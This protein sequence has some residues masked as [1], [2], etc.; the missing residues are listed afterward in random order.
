MNAKL[1][2]IICVLEMNPI[3][4]IVCSLLET[5]FTTWKDGD[6]RDIL[7]IGQPTTSL[8]LNIK[9]KWPML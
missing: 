3:N 5:Q 6:K 4:D 2:V 1:K 8:N 7:T 9:E